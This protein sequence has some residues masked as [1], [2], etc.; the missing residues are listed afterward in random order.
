MSRSQ[1]PSRN[2]EGGM[3]IGWWN[4]GKDSEKEGSSWKGRSREKIKMEVDEMVAL[5]LE[6]SLKGSLPS[7]PL[8]ALRLVRILLRRSGDWPPHPT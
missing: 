6:V 5:V 7:S 1:N 3:A 2:E 8:S 4:M